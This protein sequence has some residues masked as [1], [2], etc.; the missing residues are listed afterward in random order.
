VALPAWID[1]MRVALEEVP[2]QGWD[3]PEG[4]VTVRIDPKTGEHTSAGTE[5]AVFEVFRTNRV[6]RMGSRDSDSASTASEA[7]G[8]ETLTQELF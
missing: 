3:M 2:E 5:G 6:P 8:G 4:V 1:F 7:S